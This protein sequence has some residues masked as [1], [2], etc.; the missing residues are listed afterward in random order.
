[1]LPAVVEGYSILEPR[2][3]LTLLTY[4]VL[5]DSSFSIIFSCNKV[6]EFTINLMIEELIK[7]KENGLIPEQNKET[8]RKAL[9]MK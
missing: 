7:N 5:S 2:I 3:F 1:M 4:L 8:D 9:G 6:I